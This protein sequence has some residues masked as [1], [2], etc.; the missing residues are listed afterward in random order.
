MVRLVELKPET[1][2]GLEA[3]TIKIGDFSSIG[4]QLGT[5]GSGWSEESRL[6]KIFLLLQIFQFA[7]ML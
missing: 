2:K 5:T 4:F 6:M 7:H 3:L 1:D